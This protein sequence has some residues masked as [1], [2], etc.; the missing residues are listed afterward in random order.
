MTRD[1]DA[2]I[3]DERAGRHVELPAVPG[4]GHDRVSQPALGERPALMQAETI[5]GVEGAAEIE[6][7]DP[8]PVDGYLAALSDRQIADTSNRHKGVRSLGRIRSHLI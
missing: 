7:G 8:P 4:A 1:A 3:L 6:E 2:R 5:D